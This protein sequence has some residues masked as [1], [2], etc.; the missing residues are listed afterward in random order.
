M[1]HCPQKTVLIVD[2]E[3]SFRSSLAEGLAVFA[4]DFK[5]LTA[6]NGAAA[7]E[8]LRAQKIDLLVTD[9]KMPVMDGFALLASLRSLEEPVPVIVMS[10]YC[11][12]EIKARLNDLGAPK[13]LEKP[14]DFQEFVERLFEGLHGGSKS[15]LSGIALPAFLQLVEMEKKTCTLRI[16]SG[17]K[18]GLLYFHEGMLIDADSG[19]ER[20]EKA[21]LDIVCWPDASID[22][23]NYCSRRDVNVRSP[24][25]F[26]LLEGHRI[27][28]EAQK[29]A[30]A[31]ERLAGEAP[32]AAAPREERP[33][34][35]AREWRVQACGVSA[36]AKAVAPMTE[37]FLHEL[38]RL[39][40]VEAVYLVTRD[41]FLLDSR[42]RRSIDR[43]IIGA[44]ASSGFGTSASIG[45]Q[46]EKGALVISMI[47]FETGPVLLT[48]IG[49]DAFLVIVAEHGANL[50][51]I[52]IKLKKHRELARRIDAS[53]RQDYL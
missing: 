2:D 3:P 19:L 37:E 52:R 32:R 28:D 29:A 5:A 30:P 4:G 40:D 7:L 35:T 8:A 20:H 25:A 9:L 11:T 38:S 15:H 39:K 42:S 17:E 50:G 41:G 47:E 22:I 23:E 48:P 26:L 45:K 36:T 33:V 34:S 43:E 18:K 46:L 6:P 10:A 12:P 13:I 51:M 31:A 16:T 27:Q 44:V 53:E 1:A 21:A 49:A 24:L 14:I